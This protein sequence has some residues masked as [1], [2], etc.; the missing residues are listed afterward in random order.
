MWD[1][2]CTCHIIASVENLSHHVVAAET[3]ILRH[4]DGRQGRHF[5]FRY[6]GTVCENGIKYDFLLATGYVAWR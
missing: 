6:Y 5:P 4:G 1:E 2:Q 3:A